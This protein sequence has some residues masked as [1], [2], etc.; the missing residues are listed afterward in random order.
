MLSRRGIIAIYLS[1]AVAPRQFNGEKLSEIDPLAA[2]HAAESVILA[3][4]QDRAKYQRTGEPARKNRVFK[5]VETL[6][7]P[8]SSRHALP[9]DR[10]NSLSEGGRTN[11]SHASGNKDVPLFS[12]TRFTIGV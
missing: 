1:T 3:W 8:I 6:Q 5:L 12:L 7:C 9:L 2:G 4:R 10:I 11:G